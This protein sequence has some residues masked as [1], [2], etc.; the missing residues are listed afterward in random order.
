MSGNRIIAILLVA[1]LLSSLFV[2]PSKAELSVSAA[3]T[4]DAL[5]SKFPTNSYWNHAGTTN[6]PDK[7]TST[8]C[9]H[10]SECGLFENDC[11]C[12]SYLDAI[13]SNGFAYK[14]PADY[15]G[16]NPKN[17][18]K[19]STFEDAIYKTYGIKTGDLV[20]C[21]TPTGSVTYF[22]QSSSNNSD[23]I[24][25]AYCDDANGCQIK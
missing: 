9:S 12:N 16:T 11:E 24:V 7:V 20:H 5:K 22:V 21:Y 13:Q 14:L 17:W 15:T 19:I 18:P 2:I 10:H 8:P 6:D 25:V 4:L 1:A 3:S 23:T